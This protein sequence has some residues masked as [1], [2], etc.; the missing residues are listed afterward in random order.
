MITLAILCALTG[1]TLGLRF[2][3][4]VLVPPVVI[5][6]LV[7]T[8]LIF[9]AHLEPLTGAAYVAIAVT[10]LQLGY[11]CGAAI[12][13]FLASARRPASQAA[14]TIIASVPHTV[15]PHSE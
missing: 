1:A 8:T 4:A 6:L 5:I 11:F 7:A 10:S 9:V 13:L 12:R 15:R 2:R 14:P 3:V